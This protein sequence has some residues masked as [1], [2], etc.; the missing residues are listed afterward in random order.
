MLITFVLS[1]IARVGIVHSRFKLLFS[2]ITTLIP[3]VYLD[4]DDEALGNMLNFKWYFFIIF[5][6]LIIFATKY[7]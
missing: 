4:W 3:A 2:T 6:L 7:G 1:D 5:A